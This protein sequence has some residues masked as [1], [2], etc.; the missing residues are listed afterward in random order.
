MWDVVTKITSGLA[1]AAFFAAL[2]AVV[3]RVTIL[4][5]IWEIRE[6]PEEDRAKLIEGTREFTSINTAGL[7]RQQKYELT[8]KLIEQKARRFKTFAVII[9]IIAVLTTIIS[10]FAIAQDRAQPV[11]LP[12]PTPTPIAKCQGRAP[13]S[14][15]SFSISKNYD[16]SGSIG[17]IDDIK[18][19]K[20]AQSTLFTYETKGQGKHEWDYTYVRGELNEEPAKFAGVM[21][22]SSPNNWAE[23]PGYD[24]RSFRRVLK[25]KARSL[26]GPVNVVFVI[27]G[28]NWE[29]DH[30]K[31]EKNYTVPCPDSMPRIQTT[32]ALTEEWQAFDWDLSDQQEE[33]FSSLIGGFAWMIEWGSNGVQLNE[34]R[35]GPVEPKTFRIEITDIRYEK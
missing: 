10:L 29:W 3:Y 35:R 18:I 9:V 13:S 1:L 24:L 25:W 12:V 5:Q 33:Y 28:I 31:K 30:A 17:D 4:R 19:E 22:L 8:L 20:L 32:K 16:P 26:T 14:D 34:A 11:P 21:Y 27:G 6:A 7:S 2:A 23:Q 15:D